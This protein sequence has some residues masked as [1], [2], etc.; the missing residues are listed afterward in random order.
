M[1]YNLK[2]R[3]NPMKVVEYAGID[4]YWRSLWRD[5]KEHRRGKPYI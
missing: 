1:T 5:S 4:R 2:T 3:L